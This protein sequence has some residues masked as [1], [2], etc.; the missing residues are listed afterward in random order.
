MYASRAILSYSLR[1]SAIFD[2]ESKCPL[3]HTLLDRLELTAF[4]FQ[5]VVQGFFCCADVILNRCNACIYLIIKCIHTRDY[6]IG[7]LI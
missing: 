3:L 2:L 5:A 1:F 4:T 6:G 7:K